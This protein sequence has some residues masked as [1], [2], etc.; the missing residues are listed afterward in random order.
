MAYYARIE[1][2]FFMK[3][4]M[5]FGVISNKRSAKNIDPAAQ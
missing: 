3:E 5:E 4:G 1:N 2:I